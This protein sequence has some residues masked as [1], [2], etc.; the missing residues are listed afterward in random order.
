MLRTEQDT[1]YLVSRV[2]SFFCRRPLTEINTSLESP[3]PTKLISVG[4]SS[5]RAIFD[6]QE[7]VI[8]SAGT[9]VNR[10]L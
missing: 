6:E 3:W 2:T 4:F 7:L 10:F 8:D 5:N 1:V 9:S